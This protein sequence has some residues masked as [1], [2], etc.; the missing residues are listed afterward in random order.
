MILVY[1]NSFNNF[2][3]FVNIILACEQHPRGNR[4]PYAESLK[5]TDIF[6]PE[7]LLVGQTG[8]MKSQML[9]FCLTSVSLNL[10]DILHVSAGNMKQCAVIV[11]SKSD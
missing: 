6:P 4:Q 9:N 10:A 2:C 1:L 8:V 11:E 7:S 5:T 3:F